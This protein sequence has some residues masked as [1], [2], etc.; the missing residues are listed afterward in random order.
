MLIFSLNIVISSLRINMSKPFIAVIGIYD[1]NTTEQVTI[2]ETRIEAKDVYEAHKLALFKCDFKDNHT[3]LKL[4][5]YDTRKVL[6][7]HLKGFTI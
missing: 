3:V 4:F 6:F 2:R 7:D 5:E 1:E